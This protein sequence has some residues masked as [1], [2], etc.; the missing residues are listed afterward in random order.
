MNENY[1]KTKCVG[2]YI[3]ISP[4]ICCDGN[5]NIFSFYTFKNWDQEKIYIYRLADNFYAQF[6][7]SHSP[8]TITHILYCILWQQ[9][10]VHCLK[11]SSPEVVWKSNVSLF[12]KTCLKRTFHSDFWVHLS[13][14]IVNTVLYTCSEI[15]AVFKLEA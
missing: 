4:L 9:N 13:S 6:E 7:L 11:H 8:C 10:T 3:N 14:N 15:E 12:T 2:L 1:F 5:N